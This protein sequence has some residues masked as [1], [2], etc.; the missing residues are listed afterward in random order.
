MRAILRFFTP[1]QLPLET[2]EP[3]LLLPLELTASRMATQHQAPDPV[4]LRSL[5]DRTASPPQLNPEHTA[6]SRGKAV[7][8]AYDQ[9]LSRSYQDMIYAW[10]H[11]QRANRSSK[12]IPDNDLQ[13]I[14][15]R[16]TPHA[17]IVWLKTC[18]EVS[19]HFPYSFHM[20]QPDDVQIHLGKSTAN[21]TGLELVGLVEPRRQSYAGFWNDRNLGIGRCR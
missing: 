13:S 18:A 10:S 5:L 20:Y 21:P 1:L 17:I 8:N 16:L 11:L 6:F 14:E 4:L 15:P 3:Y 9:A 2:F 7:A 19:R 12:P